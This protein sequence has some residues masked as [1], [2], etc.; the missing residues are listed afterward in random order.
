MN[1]VQNL[2]KQSNGEWTDISCSEPTRYGI[3]SA[4]YTATKQQCNFLFGTGVVVRNTEVINSLFTAQPV[5]MHFCQIL[6]RFGLLEMWPY[7][8]EIIV[9]FASVSLFFKNSHFY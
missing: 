5:G 9:R 7:I 3:L 8:F 2:L 1:T 6:E 4:T